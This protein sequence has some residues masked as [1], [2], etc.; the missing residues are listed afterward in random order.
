MSKSAFTEGTEHTESTERQSQNHAVIILASGLSQRLGQPKQMLFK[1]GEPL[2]TYMTRLAITTNPQAIVIV[3]PDNHRLIAS[4]ITELADQYPAVQ[5]VMNSQADTGMAHSLS[6]GI[7]TITAFESTSIDRVL[8]IGVDQVLLD[9]HHITALLAGK[10]TVVAS[11]Y[12]NWQ[13]LEKHQNRD[14][15]VSDIIGLPL[16]INY[17]LLK[18]WQ[19][20]LI[21]DKGLRHLIRGL[22]AEKIGRVDN[23]QLSYDI[24]TPEQLT[25]AKQQGWLDS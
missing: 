12:H 20:E 6:L 15:T 19:S 22:P 18:Q 3:I 13:P 7:E 2:I 14:E 9:E 21:G 24:D 17:K 11:H 25:Y 10:Q 1:N 23:N 4:A 5:I 16:A 8:I